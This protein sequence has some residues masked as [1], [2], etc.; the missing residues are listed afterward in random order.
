M[1]ILFKISLHVFSHR[2]QRVWQ[3]QHILQLQRNLHK[4]LGHQSLKPL[5]HRLVAAPTQCTFYWS[6]SSLCTVFNLVTR[7]RNWPLRSIC[8]IQD[9]LYRASHFLNLLSFVRERE[10]QGHSVSAVPC[11]N[12]PLLWKCQC[13][14]VCFTSACVSSKIK[15]EKGSRSSRH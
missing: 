2:R 5:L 15:R 1:R 6:S 14:A 4:L 3:P 12:S 9:I 7:E 11:S 13:D 8:T 10:K